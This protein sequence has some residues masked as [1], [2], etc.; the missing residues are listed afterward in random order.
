[1]MSNEVSLS[2]ILYYEYHNFKY[3]AMMV[4]N[5][6]WYTSPMDILMI[7]VFSLCAYILFLVVKKQI[8]NYLYPN[9]K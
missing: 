9:D 8:R 3:A 7:I 1:M 6:P 2:F 4:R 5:T